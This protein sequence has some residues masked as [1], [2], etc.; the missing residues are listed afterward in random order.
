MKDQL[1]TINYV[2]ILSTLFP[3]LS[4]PRIWIR[5]FLQ[6]IENELK[7]NEN[8]ILFIFGITLVTFLF[9]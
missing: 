6:G 7:L 8:L 3:I 5:K 2:L 4:S 9:S 1:R